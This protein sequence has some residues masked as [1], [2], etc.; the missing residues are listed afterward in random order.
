MRL[1]Y[2]L[3]TFHFLGFR[4]TDPMH[5]HQEI[6]VIQQSRAAEPVRQYSIKQWPLDKGK[7]GICTKN[8]LVLFF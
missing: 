7:Y 2:L 3:K 1:S 5:A 8:P 4:G 6:F